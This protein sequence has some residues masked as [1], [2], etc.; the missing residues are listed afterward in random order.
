MGGGEGND[1]EGEKVVAAA[2]GV[3]GKRLHEEGI[4]PY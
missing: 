3:S 4:L 2:R 1:G